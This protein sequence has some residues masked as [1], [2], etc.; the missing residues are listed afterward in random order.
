VNRVSKLG[1]KKKLTPAYIFVES[2]APFLNKKEKKKR[3]LAG[4]ET[5]GQ[6]GDKKDV[7]GVRGPG[8]AEKSYATFPSKKS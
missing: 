3:L 4:A 8:F 6:K 2:R 7:L 1:G 5:G